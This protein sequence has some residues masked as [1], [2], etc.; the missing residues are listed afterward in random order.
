MSFTD[1]L[2]RCLCIPV[3]AADS[4]A[5]RMD[6]EAPASEESSEEEALGTK[7]RKIVARKPAQTAVQ[8]SSGVSCSLM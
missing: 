7:R 4:D 8:R 2:I 6:D 1:V 5:Y 3:E